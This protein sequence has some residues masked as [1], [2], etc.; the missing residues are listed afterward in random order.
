MM[1]SSSSISI[2]NKDLQYV[3]YLL[4]SKV[5]LARHHID[6]YNELIQRDLNNIVKEVGELQISLPDLRHGIQFGRITIEAPAIEEASGAQNPI[7][8][9]EARLRN[10]TY[11]APIFLEYKEYKNERLMHEGR[12]KIGDFPV[13]VKSRVCRLHNLPEE[14]LIKFGEDPRDP[15]GYFI[16]NGSERVIVGLEDFASNRIFTERKKVGSSVF[17]ISR[18]FSSTVGYRTKTEVRF[19]QQNERLRVY[20][21]GIGEDIPYVILMRALG[22]EKDIDIARATSVFV[23]IQDNLSKSFDE[24]S[25][26][27]SQEQAIDF[28][29]GRAAYG[30][31]KEIRMKR[32]EYLLDRVLLPHIGSSSADRV[33]KAFYLGK[34]AERAIAV[35]LGWRRPDDKDH[36]KN[37]RLRFAGPL[38]A[39]IFRQAFRRMVRDLRYQIERADIKRTVPSRHVGHLVSTR[40]ITELLNHAIAT[41]NWG[42]RLSGVSQ[43]LERTNYLSTISHLRRIQS[44]LSRSQANFEARDLHPTQWGRIDPCESPEGSNCG[45]VK[46]LSLLVQISV[47]TDVEDIIK[48]LR[49]L[50]VVPVESADDKLRRDG[51]EVYLNGTL[52]GYHP[53]GKPLMKELIRL[54]RRGAISNQVNIGYYIHNYGETTRTEIVINADP[55]R[56]RRPLIVIE[57]N[58]PK[59]K[60]EHIQK[61][62]SSELTIDDLVNLGVI[63]YLDAEEEE[64]T[65]IATGLEELT[66]ETTHLEISP[67]SIFGAIS[68]SIPFAE[69]NQSPRN[70]YEAAMAKQALGYPTSILPFNFS[71][72]SHYLLYPQVPLVRTITSD[73]IGLEN[74]P[75]GQNFVVAVISTPYNMEDALVINKASIERGLGRAISY[76][77]YEAEAQLYAMGERDRIQKPESNVRGYR[78][79]DAYAKLDE[80]GIVSLETHVTGGEVIIGR[81]SPPRFLEERVDIWGQPSYRRDTSILLK[82]SHSGYVDTILLTED[83]EQNRLVKVRIRD[84]RIPE[85][86]DK[87]ATRA[88]QKG[89]IGLIVP[90]ED[91]PFSSTGIVPDALINPHA[92]PSRMTIGHFLE[93][94]Y[95]KAATLIGKQVNGDP[96]IHDPEEAMFEILRSYG[97]EPYGEEIMINGRTGE[98]LKAKVFIGLVYYQRLHHMVKDKVHSRAR[99]Q[100]TLLTHQPTEGRARGG[101]L[102]FGEMERDCLVGHGASRLLQDRLLEESDKTTVYVCENCG[103]VG[104]YDSKQRRYICRIC[105]KNTNLSPVSISYAFKLLLQEIMS[106]GVLPRIALRERV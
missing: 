33:K 13:M 103:S 50:G 32:A 40:L 17:Y 96:F 102:R 46:N 2:T 90:Q 71:T 80:D 18:V 6:S 84:T 58:I 24:A 34:M 55:G 97:F 37:K 45:L 36:Y 87:F 59:L 12:V 54:R 20:F 53:E 48:T 57:E 67:M 99:G 39:E 75:I 86:G 41:G 61:L 26:I 68:S 14:E 10:V 51:A 9:L 35:K 70:T 98:P 21:P 28:I 22:L 76:F 82:A 94:I 73:I 93:S 16:I 88:G 43:L 81:T 63:E 77:V 5:G 72:T 4:V 3:Y 79:E 56:P 83:K 52:M 89:V 47:T 38:I 7:F 65:L 15:G 30:Q 62:R 27:V 44:T 64:S 91:M 31:P 1:T 95:G 60:A 66:S 25:E 42:R 106:L 29:G 49:S 8:P 100:V 74:N 101:G 105:G 85:I 104:Y 78:G 11:S 23:E 69:H 92:I 19:S